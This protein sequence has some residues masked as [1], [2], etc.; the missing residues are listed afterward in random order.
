MKIQN[1]HLGQSMIELVVAIG[2]FT[3]VGSA[4][5]VLA[6]D[7]FNM[8]SAGKDDSQALLY[9]EEGIEAA[10]AIRDNKWDNLKNAPLQNGLTRQ[11]GFWEF[12]G[13]SDSLG[14][15]TRVTSV[16][17]VNRDAVTGNIVTT[18]G[19][20]DVETKKITSTVTWVSNGQN[21]TTSLVSYLMRWQK[22][23]RG[24]MLVYGDTSGTTVDLIRYKLL[25][26][27]TGTWSSALATADVDGATINKRPRAMQLYSS[28]TRNE[29]VLISRHY[30]GTTQY[31]YAQVYNG[32]TATWGNVILLSSWSATTFL[33]VQNFSGTYRPDGVFFV[34]YSDGTVVPKARG[35]DG[36][37][38]SVQN[39]IPATSNI[40]VYIVSRA[41]PAI[42]GAV[43]MVAIFDQLS[44]TNTAFFN[45]T[46]WTSVTHSTA[47]PLTTKQFVD[48]EWSPNTPTKGMLIY[49]SASNDK[50]I[51]GKV[52]DA[53]TATWGTVKSSA[54]QTSNL[55]AL[56]LAG[57]AGANE[58]IACDK[59]ANTSPR[60][61]CYEATV[62]GTNTLTWTTPTNNIL[63]T[64]SD[65]GIQRSYHTDFELSGSTALNVY[66]DNTSTV[67]IKKYNTTTNTWDSAATSIT[68]ALNA[69][70]KT[71]RVAPA[72]DSDDVM[73]LL[74]DGS[75]PNRLYSAVWDGVNNI[76]YT[77]PSGKAFSAHGVSGSASTDFWYDFAWDQF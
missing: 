7:A 6:L 60:I 67:K 47:A 70:L 42:S 56:S 43:V 17:T 15:Y 3:I 20:P 24:G 62:S 65:T 66:S 30:N 28:P 18:G 33:D 11:N 73:L 76:M 31:I 49:S 22:P 2:I 72:P 19:I 48:F 35:W 25:D 13:A 16:E 8:E 14:K 71:T 34:V 36:S 75:A 40:P 27:N 10:R 69:V 51:E 55:G 64:G 4:I 1:Q 77:M 59:D 74:G 23:P 44:D 5:I 29:K 21:N 52:F 32:V 39:S 68:P 45:G 50:S 53:T 46:T 54:N 58:F 12:F 61:V 37:T 9:A 38:W 41:M 63:V 57:R 26:P